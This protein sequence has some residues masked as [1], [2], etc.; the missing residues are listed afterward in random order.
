MAISKYETGKS[1][2]SSGVLLPVSNAVGVPVEYFLRTERVELE[3]VEYRKHTKL[4][5]KLLRQ[6]EGDVIEQ[7]ERYLELEHVFPTLPI[8]PFKIPKGL[9]ERI[10]DYAEIEVVADRVRQAWEDR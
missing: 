7:I 9:P 8:K 4:P 5:K 3:E 6:I 1:T 10:N 2:P